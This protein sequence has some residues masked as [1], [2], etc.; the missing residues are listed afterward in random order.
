[1]LG[2]TN[3]RIV[4]GG[5]GKIFRIKPNDSSRIMCNKGYVGGYSTDRSDVKYLGL[6]GGTPDVGIKDWEVQMRTMYNPQSAQWAEWFSQYGN[7]I[8]NKTPCVVQTSS[9][10]HWYLSSNGSNWDIHNETIFNFTPESQQFY[11]LKFG[12]RETEGIYQNQLLNS[13]GTVGGN[14]YACEASSTGDAPAWRAFDG[15]T[16]GSENCWWS[17][18]IGQVTPSNSVSITYYSPVAFKPTKVKIYNEVAT[19]CNFKNALI[20][21]SN[22]NTNWDDLYSIVDSPDIT[23]YV[24]EYNLSTNNK[25]KYIR[26]YFT[27]GYDLTKGVSLQEIEIFGFSNR[28]Y[29]FE[30]KKAE[31]TNYETKYTLQSYKFAVFLVPIVLLGWQQTRYGNNY[32][33]YGI[34]DLEHTK[35]TIGEDVFFDGATAVEGTDF[36]N[37]GCNKITKD[38][39]ICTCRNNAT[40]IQYSKISSVFTFPKD[41]NF[42]SQTFSSFEWCFKF[43]YN[44]YRGSSAKQTIFGNNDSSD[45]TSLYIQNDV[46]NFSFNDGNSQTIITGTTTLVNGNYYLAKVVWSGTEYHL[47]LS[48]DDGATWTEEGTFITSSNKPYL[49]SS[50]TIGYGQSSDNNFFDGII[51]LEGCYIDLDGNDWW[52]GVE[53]I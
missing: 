53:T 17:G 38:T 8:D 50:W 45:T 15:N 33:N 24:G 31:E 9:N 10:F 16:T 6:S 3:A 39:E 36:T 26:I 12:K 35:F 43:K 21:G 29:Y 40:L 5:G 51:D 23:G 28:E 49:G 22:D 52:K 1:M 46:V 25:Y 32:Y 47:Y 19:P 18:A 13:N 37:V 27:A 2:Q 7:N 30:I 41:T 42:D 48:A 44:S 4:K 20:Q 34:L 11:D 14:S